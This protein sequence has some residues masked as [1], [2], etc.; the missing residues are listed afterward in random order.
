MTPTLY[1]YRVRTKGGEKAE[2]EAH[3][4]GEA[5]SKL[6]LTPDQVRPWYPMAVAAVLPPEKQAERDRKKAD[7]FAALAELNRQRRE[8]RNGKHFAG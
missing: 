4:A 7:R 1:R 3:S 8:L 5:L 6:G 2:T